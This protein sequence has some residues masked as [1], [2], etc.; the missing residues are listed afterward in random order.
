MPFVW[1]LAANLHTRLLLH[2]GDIYR[3]VPE[4]FCFDPLSPNLCTEGRS[5]GKWWF[6]WRPDIVTLGCCRSWTPTTTID[7]CLY[8][9]CTICHITRI[10]LHDGDWGYI[11]SWDLDHEVEAEG[12]RLRPTEPWPVSH[13]FLK[14]LMLWR[15]EGKSSSY[16]RGQTLARPKNRFGKPPCAHAPSCAVCTRAACASGLDNWDRQRQDFEKWIWHITFPWRWPVPSHIDF[17][18]FPPSLDFIPRLS[19][20]EGTMLLT[21][22]ILK[23]CSLIMLVY[24][25]T[26]YCCPL[27]RMAYLFQLKITAVGIPMLFEFLH[28][29]L[30]IS[31]CSISLDDF[32]SDFQTRNTDFLLPFPCP[33]ASSFW[34]T[35]LTL[36]AF[37][38]L[39]SEGPSFSLL[40]PNPQTGQWQIHRRGTTGMEW[41]S[42]CHSRKKSYPTWSG[43]DVVWWWEAAWFFFF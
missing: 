42:G 23:S 30:A 9:I 38:K 36:H 4:N 26:S 41:G 17:W 24:E 29:L 25:I 2:K 37:R 3:I 16:L 31:L 33:S 18:C 12:K 22:S 40:Q 5:K 8:S 10:K 14:K 39:H 13:L 20:G 32:N 7:Q 11:P 21:F 19:Q 1:R 35:S 27:G 28:I 6:K 34:S 15:K 43:S